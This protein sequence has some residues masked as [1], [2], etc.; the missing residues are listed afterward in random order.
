M[1]QYSAV[2]GDQI[3]VVGLLTSAD[4]IIYKKVGLAYILQYVGV[5]R[6]IFLTKW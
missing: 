2:L 6:Y 1:F 4:V 5:I 3:D